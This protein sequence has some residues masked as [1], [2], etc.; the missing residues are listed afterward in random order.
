MGVKISTSARVTCVPDD[1]SVSLGD[2]TA[3]VADLVIGAD[4]VHSRVRGSRDFGARSR[5]M[6]HLLMRE[7]IDFD[8]DAIAPK[9]IYE[10]W[11]SSLRI[12]YGWHQPGNWEFGSLC[13][14]QTRSTMP[15]GMTRSAG[16]E[17]FRH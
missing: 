8:D 10:H 4:G 3:C 1:C 16:R 17:R 14:L 9:V 7:V 12:G 6:G 5:P 11:A 15:T 2:G 13:R